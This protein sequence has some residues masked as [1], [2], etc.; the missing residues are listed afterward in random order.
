MAEMLKKNGKTTVKISSLFYFHWPVSQPSQQQ[1]QKAPWWLLV[2]DLLEHLEISHVNQM[3]HLE[4]VYEKSWRLMLFSSH[5]WS[6]SRVP[7]FFILI[8]H[9]ILFQFCFCFFHFPLLSRDKS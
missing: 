4:D 8:Y 3:K 6:N 7:I 5:M 1:Q 2:S 9:F